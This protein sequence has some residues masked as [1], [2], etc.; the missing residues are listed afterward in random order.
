LARRAALRSVCTK[1]TSEKAEEMG[2]TPQHLEA[3]EEIGRECT[4]GLAA[5]LL[6]VALGTTLLPSLHLLGNL[7]DAPPD[8]TDDHRVTTAVPAT[9]MIRPTVD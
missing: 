2:E 1:A 4:P 9:P 3:L 6:L 8:E 7:P 5:A